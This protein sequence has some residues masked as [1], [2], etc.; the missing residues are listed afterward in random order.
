M[1]N[2][3][4]SGGSNKMNGNGFDF[5]DFSGLIDKIEQMGADKDSIAEHVLDAGCEPARQAFIRNMPPNSL[6]DK[7]HARNNV[8]ITKTRKSKSGGRYRLVGA[9]DKKFIYLYYVE[10]G[11]T[12]AP[13]HHFLEKAYR[14]AQYAAKEPMENAL[15]G[16]IENHL[17]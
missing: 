14:A 6:K 11:T 13:P 10:N 7:P 8:T 16:E 1:G 17:K 4:Q 12:K 2:G 15:I 9:H 3:K 5:S